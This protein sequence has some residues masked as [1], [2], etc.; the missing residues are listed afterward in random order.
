MYIYRIM[1]KNNILNNDQ[2]KNQ[3]RLAVLQLLK[4]HGAMSRSELTGRLGCDGT[5]I[6]NIT[7]SLAADNYVIS[8]G[9]TAASG[10]G[11]PKELITLNKDACHAAG[12][13]I[14]P[15]FLSGVVIDF[16]GNIVF[17]EK[18]YLSE[19]HSQNIFL[20]NLKQLCN[21]LIAEC[22]EKRFMGLGMAT[23]GIYDPENKIIS[24][25]EYLDA[26]CGI[27]FEDFF[28]ENFNILPEIIDATTARGVAES[29]RENL[30]LPESFILVNADVGIGC[31]VCLKSRALDTRR[32][33]YNEFGHMIIN[34]DGEICEM[35]HKGC[36]ESYSAI[37]ALEKKITMAK[38]INNVDLDII[39]DLYKKQDPQTI[40]I[41]HNS[42][43]YLGIG[44]ANL[45]NIFSPEKI[46]LSGDISNFGQNYL[47]VIALSVQQH[48]ITDFSSGLEFSISKIKDEG[49]ALGAALTKLNCFFNVE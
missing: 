7:R 46:I 38:K 36:V 6:T 2:I 9:S 26:V 43:E 1:L 48:A 28:V 14:S 10:R 18:I 42:A 49:P 20:K 47:D 29:S 13:A 11:R 33:S 45:V 35:G 25:A 17:Q 30:N 16:C 21:N 19:Q 15:R 22:P 27:N 34:P 44:I 4:M 41:V 8:A 40:S 31:Y 39:L 5:T 3:N 12:I 23:F 24:K 32:G 37:P